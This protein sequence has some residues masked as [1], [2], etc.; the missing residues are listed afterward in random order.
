V[1]SAILAARQIPPGFQPGWTGHPMAE[2]HRN[3][4]SNETTLCEMHG[5]CPAIGQ[6]LLG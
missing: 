2:D 3:R 4:A 5:D 1:L 6:R